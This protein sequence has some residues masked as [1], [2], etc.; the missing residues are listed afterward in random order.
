MTEPKGEFDGLDACFAQALDA[1]DALTSFHDA[2]YCFASYSEILSS[3]AAAM[4]KNQILTR[5]EVAHLLGDMMAEA[6]TRDSSTP[7]KRT[8]GDTV[9]EGGKQ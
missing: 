6:L 9:F 2:R 7:C 4:I 8:F 5:K 1:R 3:L